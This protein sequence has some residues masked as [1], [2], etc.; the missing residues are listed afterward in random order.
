MNI[1]LW[2]FYLSINLKDIFRLFVGIRII[3]GIRKERAGKIGNCRWLPLEEQIYIHLL[4][5]ALKIVGFFVL[6]S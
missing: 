4:L 1:T 3:T 5:R 6:E 2:G